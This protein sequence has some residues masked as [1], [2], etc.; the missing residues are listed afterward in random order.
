M[1]PLHPQLTVYLG[2]RDFVDHLDKVDPVGKCARKGASCS[3]RGPVLP[4]NQLTSVPS[5]DGVVLVDPDY[6]KDRKGTGPR[7]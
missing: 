6:L 4:G 7:P 2:K 5:L 3:P 1:T